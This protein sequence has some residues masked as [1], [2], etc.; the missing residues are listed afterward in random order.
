MADRVEQLAN[1]VVSKARVFTVCLGSAER[2][3]EIDSSH[4]DAVAV[5][6]EIGKIDAEFARLLNDFVKLATDCEAYIQGNDPY[7]APVDSPDK[8]RI[9]AAVGEITAVVNEYTIQKERYAALPHWV[10]E[11]EFLIGS[12]RF[13]RQCSWALSCISLL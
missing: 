1:R 11:A 12:H 5:R 3:A 10:E 4:P 2:W 8:Q 7:N 6:K 13:F 9:A